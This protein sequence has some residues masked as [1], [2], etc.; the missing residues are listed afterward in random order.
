MQRSRNELLGIRESVAWVGHISDGMVKLGPFGLGVDA[1]LTWAPGIGELYSA[2]AGAF[3]LVQGARAGVGW[4]TLATAGALLA[5]RTVASAIPLI[6]EL[7]A[8]V[9]RAHGWAAIMIVRAIDRE[10]GVAKPGAA[11][12]APSPSRRALVGLTPKLQKA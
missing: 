6:G 4:Q 12:A 9:F 3:I 2:A 11:Q 8:S 5:L 7:F 1:I 10:L